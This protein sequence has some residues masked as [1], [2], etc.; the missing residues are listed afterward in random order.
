[1]TFAFHL[2]RA[3]RS[4]SATTTLSTPPPGSD[5]STDN[6]LSL[7]GPGFWS[8]TPQ[9]PTSLCRSC[10]F[11]VTSW[12]NSGQSL[13]GYEIVEVTVSESVLK[14]WPNP[15]ALT[16][17]RLVSSARKADSMKL[18]TRG[19]SFA[20]ATLTW[21]LLMLRCSSLCFQ[22]LVFFVLLEGVISL[23]IHIFRPSWG[24]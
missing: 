7:V 3:Y 17:L 18:L 6:I 5:E 13:S 15:L 10:P 4:A 23:L 19:S 16:Q 12:E 2:R 8:R 22:S 1:M 21:R 24:R 11:S 14:F 20:E 9:Q